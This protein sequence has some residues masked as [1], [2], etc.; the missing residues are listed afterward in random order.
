MNAELIAKLVGKFAVASVE[1][2]EKLNNGLLSLERSPDDA[3]TIEEVMREIHTLKGES[4]MLDLPWVNAVAHYTEDL[5]VAAKG[6]GFQ[7][8]PDDLDNIYAGFDLLS[9]LVAGAPKAPEPGVIDACRA[10]LPDDRAP[11]AGDAPEGNAEKAP[12]PTRTSEA[13]DAPEAEP[14]E[15][16][17][18]A[19]D[20]VEPATDE[21]DARA[22]R[23]TATQAV[24]EATGTPPANQ[25]A[26]QPR[27]EKTKKE[28]WLRVS[29]TK[30]DRLTQLGGELQL[31]H[32]DSERLGG[33][34]GRLLG[35]CRLA[36]PKLRKALLRDASAASTEAQ[37]ELVHLV[38]L[39]DEMDAHL[40]KFRDASFQG[41]IR[42]AELQ[43]E[44]SGVRM[45]SLAG[46]FNKYPRAIRD[47]AKQLGKRARLETVGDQLAADEEVIRALEDPLLH[48]LRNSVDH[49]LEDPDARQA[50]GKPAEGVVRLSA[51][52]VGTR[53]EVRIEDDG[54][55]IDARRIRSIAVERGVIGAKEAE[56]LSDAQAVQLLF[57]SGFSTAVTVTDISGRGVGLDVVKTSIERI[58]GTVHIETTVGQGTAFVLL[59]PT[60]MALTPVLLVQLSEGQFG[61]PSS[62]VV[63][64]MRLEAE[65]IQSTGGTRSIVLDDGERVPLLDLSGTLGFA[66]ETVDG[67]P[68]EH[69][70]LMGQPGRLIAFRV[71][72]LIGERP[73][74]QS[75]LNPILSGYG[76]VTG[77]AI[78]E[79]GQVL[80]MLNTARLL[81]DVGRSAGAVSVSGGASA[82]APAEPQ[83][84]GPPRVV[85]VEDSDLT[86][87]M[88]IAAVSRLGYVVDDAPNGRQGLE[89]A[90]RIRPDLIITDLDMPVLNGF[91]LI[92]EARADATLAETPIIVLS[93]RSSD[94]DKRRAAELGANAYLVKAHFNDSRLGETLAAILAGEKVAA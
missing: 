52:R 55:G 23:V 30:V 32:A 25:N 56:A 88:L 38:A 93:T 36:T 68:I 28:T 45:Q 92:E 51:A 33:D 12:G 86:R 69:A 49:G 2:I 58:G 79:G 11:D 85:V 78:L 63:S 6:S 31:L 73:A 80:P 13:A 53:L 42:V 43:E 24:V 89:L 54:R 82:P 67:A 10:F 60:T 84:A 61:I 41:R 29:T 65:R 87:E 57:A 64:V 27:A 59:L 46:L 26:E 37:H 17:A 50:Q 21:A 39:F 35:N 71:K 72:R 75:P 70:V 40:R 44:I 1:R 9:D 83:Q 18:S 14:A 62:D 81:D 91:G 34:L 8:E 20:P 16:P 66:P 5:L 15:A 3:E 22:P 48:L 74:V 90:Q 7:V 19:P 77:S 94:D 76:A 4:K 47:L